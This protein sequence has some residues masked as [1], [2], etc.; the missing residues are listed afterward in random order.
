[1]LATATTTQ[2]PTSHLG[3]PATTATYEKRKM[4]HRDISETNIIITTPSS[5]GDPKVRLID[6]DLVKVQSTTKM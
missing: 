1:M 2:L 5:E 6:M 3:P 4:R